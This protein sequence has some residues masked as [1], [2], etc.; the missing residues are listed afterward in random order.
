MAFHL[1]FSSEWESTPHFRAICRSGL[2]NCILNTNYSLLEGRARDQKQ[3]GL[4]FSQSITLYCMRYSPQYTTND[5]PKNIFV[6]TAESMCDDLGPGILIFTLCFPSYKYGPH[7][8]SFN[9]YNNSM[10]L[11]L[12]FS[13]LSFML[14]ESWRSQWSVCWR[15]SVVSKIQS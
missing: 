10:K 12:L 13:L 15:L 14:F 8:L 7:F 1:Q 11:L 2:A 5:P 4:T 9:S 3:A 6:P